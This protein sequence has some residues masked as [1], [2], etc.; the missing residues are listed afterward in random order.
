MATLPLWDS[1]CWSALDLDLAPGRPLFDAV[2]RTLCTLLLEPIAAVELCHALR[3]LMAVRSFR[4]FL[5]HLVWGCL[6]LLPLVTLVKETW[7]DDDQMDKV[8]L[9]V[10]VIAFFFAWSIGVGKTSFTTRMFKCLGVLIGLWPLMAAC[11]V[12]SNTPLLA[13]FIMLVAPFMCLF[14]YT[15][16][17]R[18]PLR[19]AGHGVLFVYLVSVVFFC[20][21][22]WDAW[23]DFAFWVTVINIPALLGTAYHLVVSRREV[24]HPIVSALPFVSWKD[25]AFCAALVASLATAQFSRRHDAALYSRL[26]CVANLGV[27]SAAALRQTVGLQ[28]E[29]LFE[30]AETSMSSVVGHGANFLYLLFILPAVP[31]LVCISL[32]IPIDFFNIYIVPVMNAETIEW[33]VLTARLVLMVLTLQPVAYIM[34]RAHNYYF[35]QFTYIFDTNQSLKQDPYHIVADMAKRWDGHSEDQLALIEHRMTMLNRANLKSFDNGILN[36]DGIWEV[37]DKWGG[38]KHSKETANSPVRPSAPMICDLRKELFKYQ[39]TVAVDKPA[40]EEK[41]TTISSHDAHQIKANRL[42]VAVTGVSFP[43][44]NELRGQVRTM[45][46]DYRAKFVAPKPTS[47]EVVA[48]C[49]AT[50]RGWHG[51][52]TSANYL[53]EIMGKVENVHYQRE[54]MGRS[55]AS[56][57]GSVVIH[58][59]APLSP[60]QRMLSIVS[61]YI[62]AVLGMRQVASR[63][64]KPHE[65]AFASATLFY[66][67]FLVAALCYFLAGTSAP[68]ETATRAEQEAAELERAREL[69]AFL[70]WS[71]R[72]HVIIAVLSAAMLTLSYHHGVNHGDADSSWRHL[73]TYI[74]SCGTLLSFIN[75]IIYIALSLTHFTVDHAET[76]RETL[77]RKGEYASD[78]KVARMNS[79]LRVKWTA[80]AA[81]LVVVQL[82]LMMAFDNEW[83]VV[84]LGWDAFVFL[85]LLGSWNK[86]W[87]HHRH[88]LCAMFCLPIVLSYNFLSPRSWTIIMTKCM[89]IMATQTVLSSPLFNV[90]F[91]L[92]A[93]FH[94]HDKKASQLVNKW[95]DLLTLPPRMCFFG[96]FVVTALTVY[97]ET[98]NRSLVCL[99]PFT[100][101]LYLHPST[102]PHLHTSTPPHLHT[103]TP[104]HLHTSTPPQ[105]MS[106]PKGWIN[107]FNTTL[108]APDEMQ[109]PKV[110]TEAVP[111]TRTP[112]PPHTNKGLLRRCRSACKG[113]SRAACRRV[114][115]RVRAAVG[116]KRQLP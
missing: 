29:G 52:S 24:E 12:I 59:L 104:P 39:S 68:D 57:M 67:S 36:T 98:Y 70:T 9:T 14:L 26:A 35:Q 33:N 13:N 22:M 42:C 69:Q 87:W 80:Y 32:A 74:L 99:V 101:T 51:G 8:R 66:V 10:A 63:L 73:M 116:C 46:T 76:A 34:K 94:S 19:R 16:F 44:Y 115:L 97:Q 23:R 40:K 64:E 91:Q 96:L 11:L 81:L 90:K 27:W 113:A 43:D 72:F 95:L 102:P 71:R 92:K 31:M 60:S 109:R 38:K 83:P 50:T 106:D 82:S 1:L 100:S 112:P 105:A 15:V 3:R 65:H 86:T 7:H 103:S 6:A 89:A 55:V 78:A 21:C 79:A 58:L 4:P 30:W 62:S 48:A 54:T 20:S 2:S 75:I 85:T 17:Y 41:S 56:H 93:K 77:A 61:C 28:E 49:F 25:L 111:P 47:E 114:L 45:L 53:Y 18:D 37:V 107:T 88:P 110:C 5:G 108:S 84:C